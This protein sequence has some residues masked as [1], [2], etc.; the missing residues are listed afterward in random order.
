MSD[1]GQP[2]AERSELSPQFGTLFMRGAVALAVRH[3]SVRAATIIGTVLLA[4][5]L[6]PSDFGVY[7]IV[8]FVIGAFSAIGDVGL[9]AAL[10]QQRQEPAENQIRVAFTAQFVITLLG[11]L[12]LFLAAPAI[13]RSYGLPSGHQDVFRLLAIVLLIG[14]LRMPPTLK[15]ERKLAFTAV[16]RAESAYSV[17][18][19]GLAVVSAVAGL[20]ALSVVIGAL[21]G[22]LVSVVLLHLSSPWRPRLSWSTAVVKDLLAFG[23]PYQGSVILSFVKDA[24]NPVFIGLLA[25]TTAVGYVSLATTAVGYTVMLS[26]ILNRLLFPSFARLR[27]E[28]ERLGR[29][30]QRTI[31]WNVFAAVGLAVVLLA[32][33]E[34]WIT[35]LFG[36]RWRP[37]ASLLPW[38]GVAVPLAAAGSPGLAVMNALRRPDLTLRFTL[39][40]VAMTWILTVPLVSILGWWGY[41]PANALVQLSAPL[42]F[43][44]LKS[45]VP[46]PLARDMATAV[47]AATAAL[48]FAMLAR[49]ALG[50]NEPM[51]S[52]TGVVVALA[53]YLAIWL[54]LQRST[55][56]QDLG[57]AWALVTAGYWRGLR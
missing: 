26:W 1:R 32:A 17:V 19:Q 5:L 10:I 28:P 15:L 57:R 21:A 9:G 25:G 3:V 31:R 36:E 4:R 37:A 53:G 29:L 33:P 7:A 47:A 35:L 50:G 14:V 12:A 52:A 49:V 18:F 45:L 20:G 55:A 16:A 46:V 24:V 22:T 43:A 13:S 54:L 41:G 56:V 8:V 48:A 40:W 30:L 23:L 44:A 39:L 6:S 27:H 2:L 42:F 11:A 34:E 38:L 51:A